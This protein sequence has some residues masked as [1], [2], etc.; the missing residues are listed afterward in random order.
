MKYY[1]VMILS[2]GV[3]FSHLIV[4]HTNKKYYKDA[5]IQK[6]LKSIKCKF[7]ETIGN[8]LAMFTVP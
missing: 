5:E 3:H 4:K 6:T 8:S 1:I 2:I 7:T